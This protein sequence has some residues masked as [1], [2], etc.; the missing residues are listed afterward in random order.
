MGAVTFVESSLEGDIYDDFAIN[1][2]GHSGIINHPNI[3]TG[4]TKA[5]RQT[6]L[7]NYTEFLQARSA[8]F[9]SGEQT[10]YVVTDGDATSHSKSGQVY[11]IRIDR[12]RGSC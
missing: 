2:Q 9:S 1:S 10:L 4:V 12:A 7:L 8:I 5:G 3:V 6:T 11:E